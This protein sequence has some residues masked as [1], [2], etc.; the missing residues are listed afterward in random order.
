MLESPPMA[1]LVFVDGSRMGNAVSLTGADTLGRSPGN[2]IVLDESGV[3][4]RHAAIDA[5]GGQ[6]RISPASDSAALS[7]NGKPVAGPQALRHGDAVTIGGIT[8]LFADDP[9]G[10]PAD[11][12]PTRAADPAD[13]RLLSTARHF[14]DAATAVAA[15][16]RGPRPEERLDL[17]VRLGSALHA[18]ARI[19]DLAR[20]LLNHLQAVFRPERA[21]LFLHD[22]Q[23]RL[24]LQARRA[25]EKSRLAGIEEVPAPLLQLS[26]DRREAFSMKGALCAP[27]VRGDRVLGL[28]HLDA[29]APGDAWGED[30]LQ[31]LNAAAS[32]ASLAVENVLA[33]QREAE[34]AQALRRLHEGSR[35][36]SSFLGKESVVREAVDQTCRLFGCSK[37]SVLLLDPSGEFLTVAGSNCIDPGIWSSVKIR[38]GEG[39]AGRAFAE[40]MPILGTGAPGERRYETSSFLVVPIFSRG[41][42]LQSDPRPIGVLSA[43]DKATGAPFTPNDR[44]L[45][46][47]FAAQVG[48]ALTNASL[49]ERATVDPLTRLYTR[50]YLDFR[51]A[52]EVRDARARGAPLSVLMCDLDHFK[53]KNDIY[54]HP[55]GDAILREAAEILRRR[56]PPPGFAARY[57][58]EEFVAVLPGIPANRAADLAQDVRLAMEEHAFNAS[59][60]PIRCTVSIGVAALGA[61]DDAGAL[62][63]R[64]DEAL[65]AAKRR[66]RNRVER[67]G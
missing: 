39:H 25:P 34:T 54:G 41:E 43:T 24:R 29:P 67:S 37:A 40:G 15:I 11:L 30:D 46:S 50:Q 12:P 64:S 3:L 62:L 55:V 56:V 22:E 60:E 35:R 27:L 51:L 44:E 6:Y 36:V 14:P 32:Q 58:G 1:R 7:V 49:F 8:L 45:F 20:Q 47:V 16:R 19:D 52:D 23:G 42:G 53:D 38:P 63:K 33:R 17:L 26:L 48:I 31:L 28:I 13:P 5:A 65:Y 9:P 18:A 61:P 4:D 21:L 57:G 66:G 2:S 59:D 10:S